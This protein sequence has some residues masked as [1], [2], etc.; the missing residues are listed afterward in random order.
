[1]E[2]ETHILKSDGTTEKMKP[3]KG[4]EANSNVGRAL[5]SQEES[6]L[7][8]LIQGLLAANASENSVLKSKHEN[9]PCGEKESTAANTKNTNNNQS[10]KEN[11]E[12]SEFYMVFFGYFH[13]NFFILNQNEYVFDVFT[14]MKVVYLKKQIFLVNYQLH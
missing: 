9:T 8:P 5:T 13:Q 1:M 4:K 10:T 11:N 6:I 3:K 2:P 14:Q 7:L 12:T